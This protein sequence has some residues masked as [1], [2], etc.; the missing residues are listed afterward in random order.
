[1]NNALTTDFDAWQSV[2]TKQYNS[3]LPDKLIFPPEVK[4][5]AKAYM[6]YP[7]IR[8]EDQVLMAVTYESNSMKTAFEYFKDMSNKYDIFPY[9]VLW[10]HIQV[11]S[12]TLNSYIFKFATME[13]R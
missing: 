1:M 12:Y 13:K 6:T 9:Q 3:S 4:E 10:R 8:V 5:Y 7:I 2:I 11:D